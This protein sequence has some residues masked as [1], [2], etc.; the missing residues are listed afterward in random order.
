MFMINRLVLHLFSLSG[1][2]EWE[3]TNAYRQRSF[4]RSM[5]METQPKS[6]PSALPFLFHMIALEWNSLCG[7]TIILLLPETCYLE[8]SSFSLTLFFLSINFSQIA[9]LIYFPLI[10][11]S[12]SRLLTSFSLSVTLQIYFTNLK[13]KP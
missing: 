11:S 3:K 5:S 1:Y 4:Y 10:P 13:Q 6:Y 12:V 8:H 7:T 2:P 9:C